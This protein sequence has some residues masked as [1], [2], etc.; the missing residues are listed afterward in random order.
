LFKAIDKKEAF[1]FLTYFLQKKPRFESV[2]LKSLLE[3]D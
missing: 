3:R 2:A 1:T